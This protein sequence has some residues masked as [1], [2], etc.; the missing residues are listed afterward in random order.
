[1]ADAGCLHSAWP[2]DGVD[3]DDGSLDEEDI[4]ERL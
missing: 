3:L 4:P 1:M 2:G